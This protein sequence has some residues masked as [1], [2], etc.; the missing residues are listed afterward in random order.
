MEGHFV[1]R[2]AAIRKV[3]ACQRNYTLPILS[4]TSSKKFILF[5]W[6]FIHTSKEVLSCT[7]VKA[8]VQKFPATKLAMRPQARR[9]SRKT[10]CSPKRF[11]NHQGALS[12]SGE[13]Q[14]FS[15]TAFSILTPISVQSW[16]KS[17]MVQW[18]IL[19][20]SYQL[21]GSISVLGIWPANSS[22]SRTCQ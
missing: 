21:N 19:G 3:Y 7:T 13:P 6:P 9:L 18:W 8:A 10:A 5:Y 2:I 14:A 15:A 22:W 1:E 17:L 12:R 20:V 11:Q 16:R 4:I